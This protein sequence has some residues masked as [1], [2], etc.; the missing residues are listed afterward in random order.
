MNHRHWN[1]VHIQSSVIWYEVKYLDFN[2][3]PLPV[4]GESTTFY[5]KFIIFAEIPQK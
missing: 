1:R 4:S 3:I 2:T 5:E